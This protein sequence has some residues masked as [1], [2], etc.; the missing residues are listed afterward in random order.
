MAYAKEELR[1]EMTSMTVNGVMKLPHDPERHASY[2]DSWIKMLKEDP[3][4]LRR[5][6]HDAGAAVK[7]LLQYDR[8]RP[9][10]KEFSPCKADLSVPRER[11][12][13]LS[14]EQ[15]Q[16]RGHDQ[17]EDLMSR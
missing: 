2:V 13:E 3:E 11:I 17:S 7:H 12:L 5:A 10:E 16:K 14:R 4:E 9:R 8:E 1:A 6:A 15:E